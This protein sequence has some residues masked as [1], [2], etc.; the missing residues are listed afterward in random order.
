MQH[1]TEIPCLFTLT[2]SAVSME[3]LI[4]ITPYCR[5][6]IAFYISPYLLSSETRKFEIE[7]AK[8]KDIMKFL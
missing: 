2:S 7:R 1:R 4:D 5:Y 3:E 8:E 6:T